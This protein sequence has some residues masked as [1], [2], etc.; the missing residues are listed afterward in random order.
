[1]QVIRFN[2]MLRAMNSTLKNLIKAV[3]GIVAMSGE[4]DAIGTALFNN[5][6]PGAWSAKAYPSLKPLA[7]WLIDLEARLDFVNKWIDLGHPNAY[8]I[9]GFFFPPAFLTGALQNF[10]RKNQHAID[11]VSFEHVFRDDITK[12]N[13]E[14]PE[15][16]VVIYGMYMEACRW[17]FDLHL[18]ADPNPKEL[19]SEAPCVWLKPVYE[20]P[21]TDPTTIY[22]AP[23]YKTLAR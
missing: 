21:P 3:K 20:R 19:F 22:E 10:A 1:M 12:D 8:W 23:L 18:L 6:V 17:D 4:L 2:T 5:Q 14:K 7:P 16:G 9:S 13:A 11:K 15:D